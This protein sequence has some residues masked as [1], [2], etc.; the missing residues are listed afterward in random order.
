MLPAFLFTVNAPFA[1]VHCAGPP[2]I[3]AHSSRL[4]PS[5]STI[6]S[7]GGAAG[8]GLPLLGVTTRGTGVHCSVSSG[9][10]AEAAVAP[11]TISAATVA[12]RARMADLDEGS[13]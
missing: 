6:A 3:D 13:R 8:V 1:T 5:N 11:R 4:R 9:R 7:D 2:S 10:W 12:R